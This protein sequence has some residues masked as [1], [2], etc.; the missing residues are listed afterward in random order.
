MPEC[1]ICGTEIG[2]DEGGYYTYAEC[3]ECDRTVC[4]NCYDVK[5]GCYPIAV[6]LYCNFDN[7]KYKRLRKIKK[8]IE[9]AESKKKLG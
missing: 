7:D 3:F 2:A 4:T 5:D 6:C 9:V 1:Y 8:R